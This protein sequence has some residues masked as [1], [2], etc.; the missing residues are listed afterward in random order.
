MDKGIS[1]LGTQ[2]RGNPVGQL[3]QARQKRWGFG[4]KSGKVISAK[5]GTTLSLLFPPMPDVVPT[6]AVVI[7]YIMGRRFSFFASYFIF[8]IL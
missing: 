7:K 5:L 6:L 2:R 8:P 4:S 3:G 1:R